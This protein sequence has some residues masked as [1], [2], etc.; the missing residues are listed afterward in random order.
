[1]ASSDKPLKFP[2]VQLDKRRRKKRELD[3]SL[4][5]SLL[6]R[7]RESSSQ[8]NFDINTQCTLNIPPIY[9]C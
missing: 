5:T 8:G 2:C 6:R 9:C 1:M 3:V 4:G 7:R